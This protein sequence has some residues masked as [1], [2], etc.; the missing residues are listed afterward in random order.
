[1]L[2]FQEILDMYVMLDRYVLVQLFITSGILK[3]RKSNKFAS[4]HMMLFYEWQ[5]YC[6]CNFLF[7]L[8][9]L[10]LLKNRLKLLPLLLPVTKKV[11]RVSC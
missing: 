10:I 8:C 6:K 4:G 7:C 2:R 1:M 9:L 5:C 3:E 11:Q